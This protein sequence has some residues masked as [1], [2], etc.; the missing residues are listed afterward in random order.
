MQENNTL[1]QENCILMLEN[2]DLMQEKCVLM[3]KRTKYTY[4]KEEIIEP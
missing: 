1:I 2:N 4:G 3:Q